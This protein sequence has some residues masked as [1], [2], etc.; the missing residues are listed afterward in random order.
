VQ[1]HR[2][3]EQPNGDS[4]TTMNDTPELT[5]E[6]LAAMSDAEFL[7][8]IAIL[9]SQLRREHTIRRESMKETIKQAQR[10]L[11]N[12]LQNENNLLMEYIKHLEDKRR[13]ARDE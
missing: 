11:A 1:V 6:Q 12:E 7:N 2:A 13:A 5:N 3:R 9:R 4:I 8:Q 10:K